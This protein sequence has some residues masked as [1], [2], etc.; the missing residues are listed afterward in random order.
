MLKQDSRKLPLMPP[1][2][3]ISVKYGVLVEYSI[4]VKNDCNDDTK[5]DC[6]HIDGCFEYEPW[7]FG[8]KWLTQRMK[9]KNLW[10]DGHRI[11]ANRECCGGKY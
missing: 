4:K 10:P 5:E 2:Q 7:G 8:C 3:G 9:L 6:K 11:H 1:I